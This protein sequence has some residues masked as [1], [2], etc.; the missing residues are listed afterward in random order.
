MRL[1]RFFDDAFIDRW[2]AYWKQPIA[3]IDALDES[4][5]TIRYE[6]MKEDQ[7]QVIARLCRRLGV[8][9]APHLVQACVES[10]RFE[11]L[12]LGRTPGQSIPTAKARKGTVGDWKNY[13]TQRDGELFQDRAGVY[14]TQLG[15]END[16]DWP[17]HLPET[18]KLTQDAACIN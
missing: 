15:Y 17:R 9:D 12:T 4:I 1:E 13:F 6:E 16:D 5:L 10:A 2:A 14:L 18:L 7:G 8:D 11:K 3:A